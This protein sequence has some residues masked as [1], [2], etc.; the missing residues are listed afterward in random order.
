MGK[1]H[2]RMER[3]VTAA[4]IGACPGTRSGV[5]PLRASRALPP[6]RVGGRSR[7]RARRELRLGATSPCSR[8]PSAPSST[9]RAP[10][11]TGAA[12]A[13]ALRGWEHL[14]FEVTEDADARHRRR[15]LDAH[16]RPRHLLRP[17]R[18]R[19]QRRHPRGPHPLRHGDRRLATRSNCT[20]SCASRSAR[21]GTTSS[22]RSVTPATTAPS[23]GCTRSADRHGRHLIG[24]T[25]GMIRASCSHRGQ[26]STMSRGGGCSSR[27]TPSRRSR[28]ER[29][30]RRRRPEQRARTRLTVLIRR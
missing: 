26:S 22:S 4:Q 28:S 15:P 24:R 8:A 12:L 2:R 16:A 20:A 7:P 18:H 9:G 23:S 19:R 5:H 25:A 17:D 13:S 10:R 3:E 1:S 27:W 29:L 6:R 30:T 21:P 14:R 11:G